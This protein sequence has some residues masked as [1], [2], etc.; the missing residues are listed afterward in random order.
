MVNADALTFTCLL[1]VCAD[2]DA[3]HCREALDSIAA[4]TLAPDAL[5]ICQDGPLPGGL[6]QV[7][8]ACGARRVVNPGPRGLH[9]NLNHAIASVRTSWICRADADDLN[10]PRRFETQVRFLAENSDVDVLGAGLIEFWPDGRTREKPM[11]MGHEAIIRRARYRNPINHMTAFVRTQALRAVG[12]YPDIPMKE[13]YGLWLTMIAHGYRLANLDEPLVRA[14]LGADF[15]RRRSGARHLA[16]EYALFKLKRN[17]A[18]IGPAVAA[19]A[20]IAR[21]GALASA[22]TARAVYETVLRR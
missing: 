16:S 22:T 21:A 12:G 5:I 15:Y 7:V 20:F 2:D 11:P 9:H 17:M 3:D 10:L 13:D 18:D 1:P 14:R 6:E 8:A 4:A 19:A